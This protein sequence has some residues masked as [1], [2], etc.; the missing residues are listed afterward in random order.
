MSKTRNIRHINTMDIGKQ[1]GTDIGNTLKEG[2]SSIIALFPGKMKPP[3]KGHFTVVKE[4]CKIADEVIVLISQKD[5]EEFGPSLSKRVWEQYKKLL[6]ENVT[7]KVSK[8]PSPVTE[9]YEIIKNKKNDYLVVYGKGEE[10]RYESITKN[11]EKYSNVEIVNGGNFEN[12]SATN[13]REAIRERNF[14]KI[15]TFLLEGVRVNDF[16]LN[17]MVHEGKYHDRLVAMAKRKD[18]ERLTSL[19]KEYLPDDIEEAI[20]GGLANNA[21]IEDLAQM[22]NVSLNSI[23]KELIKGAKVEKEHTDDNDTAIEIAMDHIYEDPEY[24]TKL[25]TLSL[26]EGKNL[27]TLYHFTKVDRVDKILNDNKLFGTRVQLGLNW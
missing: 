4:A 8:Y 2:V 12:I 5:K 13:L 21:T 10:S 19:G 1:I 14:D 25:A 20:K 26:E 9:I 11:R 17:F 23:Y 16:M 15:Q 3:H 22:H 7:I 24:Y 27:G 18:P 6:P